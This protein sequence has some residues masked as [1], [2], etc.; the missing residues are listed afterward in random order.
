MSRGTRAWLSP[1]LDVSRRRVRHP[2]R[3]RDR[4]HDSKPD[5][6]DDPDREPNRR[7][8]IEYACFPQREACANAQDEITDEVELQELHAQRESMKSAHQEAS[9]IRP[10]ES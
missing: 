6:H 4:E 3:G 9:G 7:D 10:Q 2:R 8:V 1:P 5:R